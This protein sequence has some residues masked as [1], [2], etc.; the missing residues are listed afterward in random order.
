MNAHKTYLSL[1]SLISAAF[2]PSGY[3]VDLIDGDLALNSIP[4]NPDRILF[5]QPSESLPNLGF[6]LQN[7]AG[8]SAS[9][10]L[11]APNL[12]NLNDANDGSIIGFGANAL[13]GSMDVSGVSAGDTRVYSMT[14]DPTS[15]NLSPLTADHTVNFIRNRQLTWDV[16]EGQ[17]FDLGRHLVGS[18]SVDVVLNG[19]VDDHQTATDVAIVSSSS[20]AGRADYWVNSPTSGARMTL[21]RSASEPSIIDGAN[22]TVNFQIRLDRDGS[23]DGLT[24]RTLTLDNNIKNMYY[25]SY[26]GAR[27][28][29]AA[30]LQ[31]AE[32]IS[33]E[34]INVEQKSITIQGSALYERQIGGD[35]VDSGERIMVGQ[36][37]ILDDSVTASISSYGS[38][39]RYQ[40]L[41]LSG[42]NSENGL[43]ASVDSAKLID[44]TMSVDAD[45]AYNLSYGISGE[46]LDTS[47]KGT[48]SYSVSV[49]P[50]VT[51]GEVD[52]T[53][54][55]VQTTEANLSTWFTVVE[56]R[57]LSATDRI[58]SQ[59]YV[60]LNGATVDALSNVIESD[61]S[62]HSTYVSLVDNNGG[63]AQGDTVHTFN[64]ERDV[65]DLR[66]NANYTD[67]FNPGELQ[68]GAVELGE[69]A[70]SGSRDFLVAE[71]GLQ[72][73]NAQ[74]DVG[75]SWQLKFVEAATATVSSS[76][77]NTNLALNSSV[78][79]SNTADALTA[80]DL[81]VSATLSSTGFGITNDGVVVDG[82]DNAALGFYDAG[83][84]FGFHQ[85]RLTVNVSNNIDFEFSE[86]DV[87]SYE[88]IISHTVPGYD[89]EGPPP[90]SF[91]GSLLSGSIIT[92]TN[93]VVKND[94]PDGFGSTVRILDSTEL[95]EDVT[96]RMTFD[97]A[98][99][100]EGVS[101]NGLASD[102]VD[103]SGLD[104]QIIVIQSD[105]DEAE[106]IAN[107]GTED[108]AV[109]MWWDEDNA[110]WLNAVAGNS[111]GKIGQRYSG[112]YAD[113]LEEFG[114][115]GE[116]G[117]TKELDASLLGAYG[118]DAENDVMWAIV[119]HNSTFGA[120]PEPATTALL[121]GLLCGVVVMIRRQRG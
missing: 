54:Q 62:D 120:V 102:A 101:T 10:N 8:G 108:V 22:Q 95:T 94:L 4:A 117:E 32:S 51:S 115:L 24:E 91:L 37:G 34:S 63:V 26:Y 72:G 80:A 78:T 11:S 113:F 61:N 1:F 3:A 30:L 19:G 17:V 29:R 45:L 90:L 70:H 100:A 18:K 5:D 28:G 104:G 81:V 68:Q 21:S 44:N 93:P 107:F 60:A 121:L 25:S 96:F 50:M 88:F 56:D 69:V 71:E 114:I 39:A 66:V 49:L 76:T 38:D 27:E 112:S 48:Q 43:T 58:D 33:G 83:L 75:F 99:L 35:S 109:L 103:I 74:A 64:D 2:I 86:G 55:S 85:A 15:P 59:S 92:L 14:V 41:I 42:S 97:S 9:Y 57:V 46:Q 106:L 84:G 77:S 40:R 67:T 6:V 65:D 52:A 118:W 119:D 31:K 16:T 13:S 53:L 79:V 110:R 12:D 7:S 111:D 116:D 36:S 82:G 23:V 47:E 89:P 105:Y 87:G 98:A 73:E 20:S